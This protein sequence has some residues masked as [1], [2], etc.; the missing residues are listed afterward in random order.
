MLYI[1]DKV[2][3]KY[4]GSIHNGKLAIITGKD[5]RVSIYGKERLK[6]RIKVLPHF[7]GWEEK[8]LWY[9]ES[10]LE[11]VEPKTDDSLIEWM[12]RG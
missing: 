11:L 8:T 3:I 2:R 6:Y 7:E 12:E 9:I 1:G 10:K 5:R 4:E